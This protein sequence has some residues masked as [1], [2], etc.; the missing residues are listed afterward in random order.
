MKQYKPRDKVTQKITREGAVE[1]NQTTGKSENISGKEKEADFSG[2]LHFTEEDRA[3]PELDRYI[4]KAEQAADKAEAAR[5]R[6]PKKKKLTR[7]RLYD[8]AKSKGKTK[9]RFKEV[10]KPMS[11]VEK[12]NPVSRPAALAGRMITGKAHGKI[13]EVEKENSG[14]EAAHKTEQSGED[15]YRFFKGHYKG[16]TERRRAKAAKLE[17]KQ[18]QK[19]VNFRYQKFLEEN[20]EMEE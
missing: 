4:R 19:E 6:I 12:T 10:E 14:V 17:K 18:M 2:R 13:H 3:M 9:L 5:E 20:P 1:E 11:E 16:K 7:E 15:V 8:E